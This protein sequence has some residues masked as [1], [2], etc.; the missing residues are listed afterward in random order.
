[1]RR[2]APWFSLSLVVVA[3]AAGAALG[4]AQETSTP[5]APQWVA[6]VLAVTQR[7]GSAHFSYTH[8][9]SSPNPEL[10]GTLSGH[11]VVDFTAGNVRVTEVD[12][13]ISFSSTGHQPLHPVPSTSTV[14]A[15]VLGGTVYQ[16]NPIPG[17]AVSGKY[18]VLP[19]PALPRSQRG[20][21]LA[22]NASVALDVLRGPNA[23][24]SV[25]DLGPAEV[26]GIAT[27]QYA[28][29]Y[30]PLHVCAL[31]Q[32]P[33][34]VTQRPSRVWLD[35]DGRLVRV[36][37]TIFFSNRPPR[38]VKLPAAI[39]GFPRGPVTTVATLTF[40]EFGVPVRVTAP[41]SSALLPEGGSSTGIAL[42]RS[43]P[44]PS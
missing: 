22:L 34:V 43:N 29:E 31:H 21:S 17:F 13:D 20:L 9:T 44:C 35:G 25:S 11:G 30:A 15:I 3:A 19:F 16:A 32:A 24:A 41:P 38:G 42:A 37:S 28:V 12:H 26:D 14:D 40:S 8:V 7:A 10:R 4:L 18:R 2:L 23:V 6:D 1:M 36:R 33:R 5:S 27:T 39:D